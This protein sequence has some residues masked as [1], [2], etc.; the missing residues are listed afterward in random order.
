MPNVPGTETKTDWKAVFAAVGFFYVSLT[1]LGWLYSE[2]MLGRVDQRI[3]D[4]A[5]AATTNRAA[6]VSEIERRA[7]GAIDRIR[8]LE[9]N[10]AVMQHRATGIDAQLAG[11]EHWRSECSQKMAGIRQYI[12]RDALDIKKIEDRIERIEGLVS[13]GRRE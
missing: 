4:H 1:G 10:C 3:A 9:Q 7:D 6:L 2:Y 13:K 8:Q 11:L 12:D 5:G